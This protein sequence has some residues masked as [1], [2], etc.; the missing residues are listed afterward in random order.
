MLV[1]LT[2]SINL[3]KWAALCYLVILAV[4]HV[5]MIPAVSSILVIPVVSCILAVSFILLIL[6]F[7]FLVILTLSFNRIYP[8]LIEHFSWV[9]RER[10]GLHE[11]F[12]ECLNTNT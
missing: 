10:L 9:K 1:I 12:S 3:M 11:L 7:L 4:S 5:L 2:V 6:V 8:K